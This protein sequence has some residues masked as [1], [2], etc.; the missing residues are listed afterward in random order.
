MLQDVTSLFSP[1][2]P[3]FNKDEINLARRYG[4]PPTFSFDSLKLPRLATL[5][6]NTDWLFFPLVG[7]DWKT[8]RVPLS[9]SLSLFRPLSVY[10][11]IVYTGK[12]YARECFFSFS[13]VCTLRSSQRLSR[14]KFTEQGRAVALGFTSSI[15][16]F[17]FQRASEGDLIKG[18]ETSQFL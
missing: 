13:P 11:H 4:R 9:L 10:T 5:Y 7:K 17:F 18:A 15:L 1:P 16:F 3:T 12:V 6:D 14:A 2:P 8:R